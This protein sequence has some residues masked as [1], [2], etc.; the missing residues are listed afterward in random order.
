[1]FIDAGGSC[2]QQN[3]R[4]ESKEIEN[5]QIHKKLQKQ[6]DRHFALFHMYVYIYTHNVYMY[7]YMGILNRRKDGIFN[8]S[9]AHTAATW[10]QN[11]NMPFGRGRGQ[12]LMSSYAK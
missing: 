5:F 12:H 7:T 6:M 11:T 1:M 2:A 4:P 8:R 9:S 10:A 3:C